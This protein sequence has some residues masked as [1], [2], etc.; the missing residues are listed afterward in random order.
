MFFKCQ[1]PGINFILILNV[2]MI[3]KH[4]FNPLNP[5]FLFPADF[6][7]HLER[8]LSRR[9]LFLRF[10]TFVRNNVLPLC[11]LNF[12]PLTSNLKPHTANRTQIK[13]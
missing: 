1:V 3:D 10:L 12:T 5:V 13:D 11:L 7:C 9:G 2:M 8:L 6:Y 4:S